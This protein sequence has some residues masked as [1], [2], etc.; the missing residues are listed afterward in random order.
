MNRTKISILL[1]TYR[2]PEWLKLAIT[3]VLRQNF[4]RFELLI[5][6]D[7]SGDETESTVK[8]FKDKRIRY[9]KN[10]KNLGFPGTFRRGVLAATGKYIFLLS[11]DDLILQKDTL[12]YVYETMEQKN[13]GYAQLGLV[14]YEE[15]PRN[16]TSI[17]TTDKVRDYYIPP[18]EAIILKTIN[19]HIG[20]ASGNI[21]LTEAV[22]LKDIIENVWLSHVKPIFRMINKFGAYYMGSRFIL[23]R[24]SKTGNISHLNV[25]V[26]KGYHL[27]SLLKLYREFDYSKER[28]HKFEKLHIEGVIKSLLGIK[29]YTSSRNL[30]KII[31]VILKINK[32]YILAPRL[33]INLITALMLP[34]FVLNQI[35]NIRLQKNKKSLEKILKKIQFEK[36]VSR[37]LR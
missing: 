22:V 28:Y 33:W 12:S 24:I 4:S 9:L 35:R 7:A 2:R 26:N 20:F 25:D 14:F 30:L 23:G 8:K 32:K 5:L 13:L 34:K 15:S 16:P 17:A 19:W 1:T 10:K 3:S 11:D 27:E 21:Y 37:L 6:D 18:S 36:N 29:Y 31:K